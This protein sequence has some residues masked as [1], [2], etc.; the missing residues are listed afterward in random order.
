MLGGLLRLSGSGTLERRRQSCPTRGNPLFGSP[1]AQAGAPCSALEQP[2][3]SSESPSPW[4]WEVPHLPWFRGRCPSHSLNS[5]GSS[6]PIWALGQE[7]QAAPVSGGPKGEVTSRRAGAG[8][9]PGCAAGSP[10]P[11]ATLGP[12]SGRVRSRNL[13]RLRIGTRWRSRRLCTRGLPTSPKGHQPPVWLGSSSVWVEK[14]GTAPPTRLRVSGSH[15]ASAPHSSLRIF[16]FPSQQAAPQVSLTE[17]T[18][19]G[20]PQTGEEGLPQRK[21]GGRGPE[22]P[23]G[24]GNLKL[25]PEGAQGRKSLWGGFE[26]PSNLQPSQ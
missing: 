14:G 18:P 8:T 10:N 13:L 6:P 9:W 1:T 16:G 3:S 22:V 23:P 17:A 19:Q 24:L 15:Q 20:A 12:F 26:G 25:R 21:E 11:G 5:R 7:G 4:F 2:W